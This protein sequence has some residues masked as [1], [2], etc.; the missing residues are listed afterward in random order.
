MAANDFSLSAN[1]AIVDPATGRPSPEFYRYLLSLS[2]TANNALGGEVLTPPGSGL[3][4]GGVVADGLSLGLDPADTRNVDHSG[5][6]IL[7][8][9]GLSGGGTIAA[10]RT[11]NLADTAVTPGTYGDA[12]NVSRITVDQQGR[13]TGV[14]DV[15]IPAGLPDAPSDGATYGRLNATW[16]AAVPAI[17]GVDNA[18]ARFDGVAGKIQT[19]GIAIDDS[20]NITGA[21]KANFSGTIQLPVFT[22]ATLPT[23]TPAGQK[24]F[25]SDALAPTLTT[26]VVGGG[27]VFTPAYSDG[28]NWK[29]G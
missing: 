24:A 14:V 4:G 8:G 9:A 19:S 18:I 10:S 11:L 26:N 23:A 6:S 7:P 1:A 28:T 20:N 5:V 13:V 25:V 3:T 29:V 21:N 2:K 22:V 12:S 16:S 17:T 15:P 27:A